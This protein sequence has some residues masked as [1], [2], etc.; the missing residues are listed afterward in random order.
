MGEPKY[1]LA[2]LHGRIIEVFG[3][4]SAFNKAMG[5]K[6]SATAGNKLNLKSPWRWDEVGKACKLLN[7]P[8]GEAEQYIFFS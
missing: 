8:I 2:K 1:T 4:T 3:S 6:S 7:I 5:W